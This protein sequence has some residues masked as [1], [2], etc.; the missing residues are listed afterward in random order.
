VRSPITPR[1]LDD[2]LGIGGEIRE[3][4]EQ[5]REPELGEEGERAG[6]QAEYRDRPYE[7]GQPG[8]GR[9]PIHD[10]RAGIG[11]RAREHEGQQHVPD[12]VQEQHDHDEHDR[13]RPARGAAYVLR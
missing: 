12:P 8:S 11:R 1:I 5:R 2:A 3:L 10:R 9:E 7:A 6:E 4:H 13:R